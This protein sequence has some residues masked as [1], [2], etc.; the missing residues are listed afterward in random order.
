MLIT[1]SYRLKVYPNFHK[2]EELR[3][4]CSRYKLYLQSFVN[5]FYFQSYCNLKFKD[6]STQG[7][8][9]LGNKAQH[10]AKGIVQSGI[11]ASKATGLKFN[12]PEVKEIQL[13]NCKIEKSKNT[14][15]D[16]W[17]NVPKLWTPGKVAKIPIKSHKKINE[18]LKKGWQLSNWCKLSQDKYGFWWAYVYVSKEVNYPIEKPNK[19]GI[20]VGLKHSITRSDNYLGFSLTKLLNKQLDK[21]KSRN[22]NKHFVKFNRKTEIKQKLNI[23]VNRVLN[24]CKLRNVSVVVENPKLLANL[25]SKTMGI[26]ARSYFGN[27]LTVRAIEEGI[28]VK[29][30]HP[31]YTSITCS[32][33]KVIDKK[34]RVNRDTFKCS[35][36]KS[37][38][39]ADINAARNIALKGQASFVLT[40]R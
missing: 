39:H 25:S 15:F 28:F 4:A 36:C 24:R 18:K 31:A 29:Y 12:L 1:R 30:I 5:Y 20:D 21:Q 23:E 17:I 32:N 40:K 14:N 22:K 9:A 37:E 34:S 3:Y 38:F 27:R 13:T 35:T 6:I 11:E 2:L 33:C 8:G 26:W 19:L 7:M 16:Y 10:E